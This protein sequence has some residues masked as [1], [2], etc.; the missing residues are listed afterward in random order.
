MIKSYIDYRVT[1][2]PW[3]ENV[4]EN[5]EVKQLVQ[6]AR[7]IINLCNEITEHNDR[8]ERN[9]CVQGTHERNGPVDAHKYF[10]LCCIPLLFSLLR[11]NLIVPWLAASLPSFYPSFLLFLPSST[12]LLSTFSLYPQPQLKILSFF[13]DSTQI[14]SSQLYWIYVNWEYYYKY[15]SEALNKVHRTSSHSAVCNFQCRD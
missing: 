5:A 11:M 14:T 15:I 3:G 4:I 13:Q 6:L 12:S 2:I 8:S 1:K 9:S 7:W 10:A